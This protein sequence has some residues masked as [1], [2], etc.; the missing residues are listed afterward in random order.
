MATMTQIPYYA[1]IHCHPSLKPFRYR[2]KRSIWEETPIHQELPASLRN[3]PGWLNSVSSPRKAES[4]SYL[5]LCKQQGVHL[6]FVSLYPPERELFDFCVNKRLTPQL[7]SRRVLALTQHQTGF[8][9]GCVESYYRNTYKNLPVNYFGELKE[10]YEYLLNHMLQS[11]GDKKFI[12]AQDYAH[13]QQLLSHEDDIIVGILTVA[14]GH[15]LT[16]HESYQALHTAFEHAQNRQSNYFHHYASQYAK[17]IREM[18]A[19]GKGAYAPLFI[20]LAHHFGNGLCGHA[21]SLDDQHEELKYDQTR[22]LNL[23]I[24]ALGE[25]VIHQLLSRDNGRRVLIDIK[26]MSANSRKEFYKLWETYHE[27]GDHFPIVCS[28][29]AVNGLPKL[30]HSLQA[31]D[32]GLPPSH[33]FNTWSTNLYDE[34][35]HYIHTSGGIIG[36]SLDEKRMPGAIPRNLIAKHITRRNMQMIRAEYLRLFMSNILHIV[37]T[38]GHSTA[39]DMICMGTDTDGINHTCQVYP[40]MH[41]LPD[42]ASQMLHFLRYPIENPHMKPMLSREE[43]HHLMFGLTPEEIVAKIMYQNAENFLKRYFQE[44]YLCDAAKLKVVA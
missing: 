43:I 10:E 19:W 35:L 9:A 30:S 22:G 24:T 23:G 13:V 12:L 41:I 21:K 25:T 15:A 36:L 1:D 42:L 7:S 28:H 39:W 17:H 3:L 38:I 4:G 32:N 18:K 40:D 6:V 11:K 2:P 33:Y 5:N 16:Q 34:E 26:H 29:T 14:G 27:K 8:E 37:R 20:S 44:D 31:C